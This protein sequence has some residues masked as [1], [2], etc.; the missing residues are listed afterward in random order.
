MRISVS[1][2]CDAEHSSEDDLFASQNRFRTPDTQEPE[3]QHLDDID[4][5]LQGEQ[6]ESTTQTERNL[7]PAQKNL[8]KDLAKHKVT[9]LKH[10]GMAN[11]FRHLSQSGTIF[12]DYTRPALHLR[13]YKLFSSDSKSKLLKHFND[14]YWNSF[15]LT[16]M[17]WQLTQNY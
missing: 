1:R 16:T 4:A 9:I 3:V 17:K 10:Q 14:L 11:H 15:L 13:D 12:P 5:L 6:L 8:I 7:T 2:I